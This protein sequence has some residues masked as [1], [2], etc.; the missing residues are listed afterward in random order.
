MKSGLI[1]HKGNLNAYGGYNQCG[2]WR[3]LINARPAMQSTMTHQCLPIGSTACPTCG[4]PLS[5]P[6]FCERCG[7]D[8]TPRHRH[9]PRPLPH[10]CASQ[11]VPARCL[12]CGE[13][14]PDARFCPT[15]GMAIEVI[16]QCATAAPQVRRADPV[17][18][19]RAL[20]LQYCNL[21]G[22][23][24]P[25]L[26]FCETCGSETSPQHVCAPEAEPHACAPVVI[27]PRRCSRCGE[28]MPAQSHCAK[29]GKD[30]TPEH[31]CAKA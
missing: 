23:L 17:H 9:S 20:P 31:V 2:L 19:C 1:R 13:P 21:C 25:A 29:C 30:I 12:S 11:P 5:P 27:M 3:V 18:V 4:E 6:A 22:V 10:I 26:T 15:C 8:I 7:E 16:H 24:K 14:L 28:L